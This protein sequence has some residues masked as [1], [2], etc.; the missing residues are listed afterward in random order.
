MKL[1]IPG[2]TLNIWSKKRVWQDGNGKVLTVYD[3]N[4]F[5]MVDCELSFVLLSYF[6][7]D[8]PLDQ[9]KFKEPEH[10]D[11]YERREDYYDDYL[12]FLNQPNVVSTLDEWVYTEILNTPLPEDL[13]VT[14][15]DSMLDGHERFEN[16]ETYTD[17]YNLA[18][19]ESHGK[20]GDTV[21]PIYGNCY[22]TN[23]WPEYSWLFHQVIAWDDRPWETFIGVDIRC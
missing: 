21:I 20:Y 15:Y 9:R 5:N 1:Q 18:S 6:I 2:Y 8:I 7:K 23:K 10:I 4:G 19:N 22:H 14:R 3:G 17:L 12:D 11:T 16:L 13:V